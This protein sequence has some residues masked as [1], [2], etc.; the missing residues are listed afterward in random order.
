MKLKVDIDTNTFVRFFA[1]GAA[2]FVTAMLLT[3]LSTP[4][5]IIFVSFFL[6][7]ALTPPVNK[8]IGLLPGHSRIGAAALSYLIVIAVLGGFLV[9]AVP[10]AVNQT[11]SFAQE[12]PRYIDS[13]EQ[14]QG[15][16]R[17]FLRRYNLE[18]QYQSSIEDAK[19]RVAELAS[20]LGS[21]FISGVGALFS[22]V[23]ALITVLV[24]TFLM[25]V[26]GPRWLER[27][28]ALYL[29]DAKRERHE[30]L[31]RRMFNVVTSYVNGQVLVATIAAAGTL[32][33]LLLLSGFLN[34]PLNAVLPLSGVVLIT[35]MIP[36]IG[37]TLGAVVVTLVLLFNDV[38]AALIFLGYFIVYQ[39]IENNVVQPAVQSRSVE[40]SALAVIVAV[41]IGVSLFGILGALVS[42]PVAGCI[43]VLVKD[44]IDH[45]RKE[46]ARQPENVL[47]KMKKA[48]KGGEA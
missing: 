6:A 10:P 48:L 41:L 24:L 17:D 39:Q 3:R 7:I 30:R 21:A 1:I 44:F 36:M 15:P 20:G 42:I 46:A 16:V 26:E 8:L 47:H 29:D 45:R 35:S 23:I 43:R 5:T 34:V 22:G 27:I 19:G 13:L 40:L 38:T 37:A 33:V 12:V 14:Q 4:L 31:A 25:I 9:L 18:A 28:W 32:A 11:V 2:F